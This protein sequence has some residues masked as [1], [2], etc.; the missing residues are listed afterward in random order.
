MNCVRGNQV[1]GYYDLIG[2]SIAK[3]ASHTVDGFV[4]RSD[5][6]SGGVGKEGSR[7]HEWIAGLWNF[8]N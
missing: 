5:R 2:V 4:S 6:V 7:T 1:V 8:K 3:R